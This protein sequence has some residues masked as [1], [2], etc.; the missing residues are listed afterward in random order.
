MRNS[1]PDN[2][3]QSPNHT[4]SFSL[5]NLA[6]VINNPIG[7]LSLIKR[8]IHRFFSVASQTLFPPL[9]SSTLFMYIFGIAI[10]S[11]VDFSS[12]GLSYFH[13]I[14]PGLMTMYLISGAYENTSSSLFI[15]RW[16]N[17]IQEVLLSPLSYFE[18]VLGLLAGGLARGILVALG[19]FLFSQFF[20]HTQLQHPLLLLY[21]I[22]TIAVIFSCAGMMAALWAEDFGMLN[23]WNIY[24]IMP[25]VLLGGVF[26]PVDILPQ[27]LKLFT[28]FN[29]MYFLVNGM[30]FSVTGVSDIP[31]YICIAV[32]F[33]MAVCSFYFTVFLFKI[34]YKL[35]T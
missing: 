3:F 26:Y 2:S 11:R 14:V 29:P 6:F 12:T 19:V 27:M 34:G 16:H 22:V 31:I 28:A 1:H 23:I 24:L 8:E 7:V 25:L 10:G 4:D 20:D 32:S 17:H 15:A 13:F 18:M 35:R 33:G 21:F 30:R 9:I 5:L